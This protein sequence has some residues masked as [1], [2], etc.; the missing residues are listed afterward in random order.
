MGNP[1][2]HDPGAG[3]RNIEELC[4]CLPPRVLLRLQ[5]LKPLCAVLCVT[6]DETEAGLRVRKGRGTYFNSQHIDEPR[7]FAHALV[8]HMLMDAPPTLVGSGGPHRQVLICELAPDTQHFQTFGIVGVNQKVVS[9][10]FSDDR[11]IGI[12][13]MI[14]PFRHHQPPTH[15]RASTWWRAGITP[16]KYLHLSQRY[17]HTIV[18]PRSGRQH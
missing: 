17:E 10:G 8:D 6:P 12:G 14:R 3:A 13:R 18:A 16:G 9:H 15:G 2:C 7:V 1:A 4:F 5:Y 11:D